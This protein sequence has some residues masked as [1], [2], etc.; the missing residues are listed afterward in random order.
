[1]C[2]QMPPAGSNAF[3]PWY[4]NYSL[5][6]GVNNPGLIMSYC[7]PFLSHSLDPLQDEP[8]ALVDHLTDRNKTFP[9]SPKYPRL[10]KL[11]SSTSAPQRQPLRMNAAVHYCNRIW[12]WSCLLTDQKCALNPTDSWPLSDH[13]FCPSCQ[14]LGNILRSDMIDLPCLSTWHSALAWAGDSLHV[15]SLLGQKEMS[16]VDGVTPE[17]QF[18]L[19]N[20]YLCLALT[21]NITGCAIQR[22][23]WVSHT[24][25]CLCL[26]I[27][28]TS[29]NCLAKGMC[30]EV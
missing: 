20:C 29:S 23:R 18:R 14:A 1:M 21:S 11:K 17:W 19:G 6:E 2:V 5:V 12:R 4:L 16:L 22:A 13:K 25:Q 26:N 10:Q 30:L 9:V 27:Q 24:G 15:T 7:Y 28:H 3:D 8:M